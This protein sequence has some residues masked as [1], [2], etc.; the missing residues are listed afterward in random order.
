MEQKKVFDEVINSIEHQQ[1]HVQNDCICNVNTDPIRIFCSGVAGTIF[2]YIFIILLITILKGTGKS[3]LAEVICAKIQSLFGKNNEDVLVAVLAPTGLAA[4]N[5][6]GMTIRSC[7]K[8]PVQHGTDQ[9]NYELHDDDLKLIRNIMSKIK[10][11]II[12]KL[13]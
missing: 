7:F 13:L 11:F 3:F 2:T 6:N 12:G 9:V 8:L 5:I 4:Y 10:L 1:S